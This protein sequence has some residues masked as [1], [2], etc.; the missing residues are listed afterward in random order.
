VVGEVR[1]VMGDCESQG[2]RAVPESG[3]CRQD[4]RSHASTCFLPTNYGMTVKGSRLSRA[5]RFSSREV[6]HYA[7]FSYSLNMSN[8]SFM[9]SART[10]ITD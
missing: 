3:T 10:T 7:P 1:K 9:L 8:R 2:S 6:M 4:P 5:E